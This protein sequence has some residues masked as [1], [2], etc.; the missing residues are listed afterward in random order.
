MIHQLSHSNSIFHQYMTELRDAEIQKDSMRFR[1]NLQRISEIFAYEISK[2]LEYQTGQTTTPL[3]VAETR[4]LKDQ[5]VVACILRAGLP[6]HTGMLNVFDKAENAFVSAHRRHHKNS[7]FDI[8]IESVSSADLNNK[9]L[10]L[11]DPMLASGASI[12]NVYKALL[13][14]GQPRHTHLVHIIGSQEGL[15]HVKAHMPSNNYTI[16]IGAVDEELTAHS[17]IVPGLGDA[18][19][20][21]FGIK[22]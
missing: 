5:P 1:R 12:V 7:T 2:T 14:K 6:M 21:A 18:G 9:T 16:W 10:I 15:E 4:Q 19:D 11:C 17:Y 20:L 8:A 13:A 3:G 22:L